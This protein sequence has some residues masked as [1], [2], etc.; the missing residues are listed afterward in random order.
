[1]KQEDFALTPLERVDLIPRARFR[2]FRDE[3]IDLQEHL[4]ETKELLD[5][6]IDRAPEG[7]VMV[8][9]G[10]QFVQ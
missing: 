5:F 8:T 7:E 10:A 9:A 4:G 3:G 1:M 2:K 6:V